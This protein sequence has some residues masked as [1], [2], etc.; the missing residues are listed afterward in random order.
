MQSSSTHWPIVS[1]YG[2][3]P[4]VS[5][6]TCEPR[7]LQAFPWSAGRLGLTLN[8]S[9]LVAISLPNLSDY[10]VLCFDCGQPPYFLPRQGWLSLYWPNILKTQFQIL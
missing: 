3:P 6:G 9:R 1:Q 8:M 5:L 10:D 2:G 4:H 7:I